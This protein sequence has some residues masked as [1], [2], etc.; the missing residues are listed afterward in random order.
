MLRTKYQGSMPNG[1]RQ[2]D[3]SMFFFYVKHVSPRAGPFLVQWA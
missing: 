1:S 2:E 3:F